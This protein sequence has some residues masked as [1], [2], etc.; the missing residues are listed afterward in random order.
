MNE[1][2]LSKNCPV[3]KANSWRVIFSGRIRDG[4]FG[5]FTAGHS[6]VVACTTCSVQRLS[7]FVLTIDEY[8]G[9]AYRLKYNGSKNDLALLALHDEEQA[10]R[11][12]LIGTKLLRGSTVIDVGCGHG[13]FLDSVG[14]LASRTIG[15]EP[16]TE[17]HSSLRDRGH[18][19]FGPLD[20]K[21]VALVSSADLVT[22]FGVIEHLEDPY[23]HL[24]LA[25]SFVKSGGRLVLLTDNLD[26]ILL[27]TSANNFEQFFYRTAHNWYFS[28]LTLERLAIRAGLKAIKISTV[29]EF[30][31]SNFMNWH[32]ESRPTGNLHTP[33]LGRDFE[34]VWKSSVERTGHGSL[35]TMIATK[36]AT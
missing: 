6:K 14:G 31:F 15:I 24:T 7:D 19:I 1:I 3:C 30:N 23:E 12:A 8:E 22:S 9:D 5:N 20:P 28:P 13:A 18:E 33:P 35:V 21:I 2:Q 36:D 25:W 27:S 16:F 32:K 34:S 4:Q 29:H 26:E 17:L 10:S 11:M